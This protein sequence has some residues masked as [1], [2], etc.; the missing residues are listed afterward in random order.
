M[1]F[2]LEAT[3]KGMVLAVRDSVEKDYGEAEYVSRL[4]LEAN[5]NRYQKLV[6]FRLAGK[7]DDQNFQSRLNDEK[8][9]LEAQLNTLAIISK[10]K[11]QNA[12]NA[13][14]EVLESAVK[15]CLN[16]V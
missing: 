9:M 8:L 3:I 12:A 6:D 11:A 10:V 5:K 1:K 13:A 14:F 7:I 2:D 16:L 15:S 4:F